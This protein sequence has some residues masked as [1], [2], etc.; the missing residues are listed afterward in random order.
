MNGFAIKHIP[1]MIVHHNFGYNSSALKNI[2]RFMKLF[3][4]YGKGE[5]IVIEKIPY[6]YEYFNRTFEIPS[7]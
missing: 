6:Y 2:K 5:K 7:I 4:K 3:S 1:D